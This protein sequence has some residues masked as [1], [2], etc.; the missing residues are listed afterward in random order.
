MNKKLTM[1]TLIF[2]VVYEIYQIIINANGVYLFNDT[3]KMLSEELSTNGYELAIKAI[4]RN[5]TISYIEIA[6]CGILVILSV[7][8]CVILCGKN[9]KNKKSTD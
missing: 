7:I 5:I 2:G 6:I 3:L 9:R 8:A 1:F 4:M